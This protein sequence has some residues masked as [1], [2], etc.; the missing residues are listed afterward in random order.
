MKLQQLREVVSKVPPSVRV[1]LFIALAFL[2]FAGSSSSY[3]VSDDYLFLGRIHLDNASQYFAKSMGCCNEYRPLTAYSYALDDV[4]SGVNPLGYHVTAIALHIANCLLAGLI[5]RRLGAPSPAA[6][7]TSVLFLLN[8]VA[9]ES[10]LWIA[11]RPILLSTFFG[12]TALYACLEAQRG[13]ALSRPWLWPALMHVCFVAAL[14]CYEGAVVI[15]VLAALFLVLFPECR[16]R[17]NLLNVAGLFAILLVYVIGWNLLFRFRIQR[18]PVETSILGGAASFGRA[19][20]AS[21]HGCLRPWVLPVYALI[22]TACLLRREGRRLALASAAWFLIGYLPF[23]LV[24]GFADR[25]AYLSSVGTA[26]L[27]GFG[28]Y[29]L[30][31]T[32]FRHVAPVIAAGLLVFFA[33]GMQHRITMWREAGAIAYRIPRE[34]KALRPALPPGV[35]LVAL[36]LPDMHRHALV[37]ITGLPSAIELQY[38]GA[39]FV[40]QTKID[41][42]T[43]ANAIVFDCSG[44]HVHEIAR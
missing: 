16:T 26:I 38:P 29:S 10:V 21:L 30:A 37:F 27:L 4:L 23:F 35:T 14:L 36:N 12:L 25:F 19:I 32:R 7:L 11:A 39:S 9:H 31:R 6:I 13:S 40:V 44:N 41:V 1:L 15:P 28:I 3:F 33:V 2:F 22:V 20:T 18:F 5:A 24:K 17:R 34:M 43:P 8:P 42:D